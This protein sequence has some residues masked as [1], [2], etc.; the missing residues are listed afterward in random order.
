M[1]IFK[2]FVST[3]SASCRKWRLMN[4]NNVNE[5][6]RTFS[7]RMETNVER[8]ASNEKRSFL[9]RRSFRWLLDK[10]DTNLTRIVNLLL[11][12]RLIQQNRICM[13]NDFERLVRYLAHKIDNRDE[14][15]LEQNTNQLIGKSS[16][17]LKKENHPNSSDIKTEESSPP[18]ITSARQPSPLFTAEEQI[19][20]KTPTK[21]FAAREISI[22]VWLIFSMKKSIFFDEIGGDNFTSKPSLK[23]NRFVQRNLAK[24]VEFNKTRFGSEKQWKLFRIGGRKVLLPISKFEMYPNATHWKFKQ[25]RQKKHV[26]S[27]N[28]FIFSKL[29][30][31][32]IKRNWMKT[33]QNEKNCMKYLVSNWVMRCRLLSSVLNVC[34]GFHEWYYS[35]F[36]PLHFRWFQGRNIY[37]FCVS[38]E[39]KCD[40]LR[41]ENWTKPRTSFGSSLREYGSDDDD[42]NSVD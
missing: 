3:N 31:F 29:S 40:Q 20:L 24:P 32:L 21:C 25:K 36:F 19:K 39:L 11:T 10:N 5:F 9:H 17:F 23:S 22:A 35:W 1:K 27:R 28:N 6:E 38:I 16:V 34:V 15:H 12:K 18:T 26:S 4:R 37:K 13:G 8:L 7:I 41:D 14:F 33:I 2:I 30:S 42:L